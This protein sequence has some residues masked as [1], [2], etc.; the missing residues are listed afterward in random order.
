MGV[1]PFHIFCK[2]SSCVS[3]L[4]AH[5]DICHYLMIL[6]HFDQINDIIMFFFQ[7]NKC[8]C[9]CNASRIVM[10]NYVQF[11]RQFDVL[12]VHDWL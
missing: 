12:I 3:F 10:P 11:M 7:L 2:E 1:L 4:R 6:Y 8:S 9:H 5:F